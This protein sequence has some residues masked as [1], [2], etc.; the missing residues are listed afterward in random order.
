MAGA[1][2]FALWVRRNN[3]KNVPARTAVS[4]ITFLLTTFLKVKV[5]SKVNFIKIS[6]SSSSSTLLLGLLGTLGKLQQNMWRR[7]ESHSHW[8]CSTFFLSWNSQTRSRYRS[9][10]LAQNGGS[11]SI[12]TSYG[13]QTQ[14]CNNRNC[15]K[16]NNTF[17]VYIKVHL[18]MSDGP[19]QTPESKIVFFYPRYYNEFFFVFWQTS[20]AAGSVFVCYVVVGLLHSYLQPLFLICQI[21]SNAA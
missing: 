5:K 21:W 11:T 13:S 7:G 18:G 8:E 15:R 3:T 4:F 16:F 1:P 6:F 20:V 17:H 9:C 2:Q 10:N 12:C 14:P 19:T